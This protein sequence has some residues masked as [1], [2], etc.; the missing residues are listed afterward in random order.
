MFLGKLCKKIFIYI[1]MMCP[2]AILAASGQLTSLRTQLPAVAGSSLVRMDNTD[3][4]E[5]LE[6]TSQKD[7]VII[8][9]DGI[10]YIQ[11]AGQVGSISPGVIGYMD[12][13]F[14]KNG[15]PIPNSNCRATVDPSTFTTVLISQTILKLSKGDM[16]GTRYAASGP[17]L[18]FIFMEPDNEP[19]I[20]S[21]IFSIFKVR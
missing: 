11:S 17:S 5:N 21:L 3:Y 10:Y 14:E 12:I 18:G 13:W 8:K 7:K 4:L 20:P 1:G 15:A 2:A 19:A 9:E 6:L 16:I